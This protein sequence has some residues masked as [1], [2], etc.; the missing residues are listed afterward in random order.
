MARRDR[1]RPVPM[2]AAAGVVAGL[3][4]LLGPM[5][6]GPN[7]EVSGIWDNVLNEPWVRG[8]PE[9]GPEPTCYFTDSQRYLRLIV[10]QYGYEVAGIVQFCPDQPCRPEERPSCVPIEGGRMSGDVLTFVFRACADP[11]RRLRAELRLNPDPDVPWLEGP[12]CPTDATDCQAQ[13]LATIK[14]GGHQAERVSADEKSCPAGD[15]PPLRPIPVSDGAIGS[16]AGDADGGAD[17]GP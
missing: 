1:G 17:A 8:F 6:C 14:L 11:N 16:A 7:D 13:R 2:L 3:V 9:S 12:V 15:R 5:G 10:G 4:A